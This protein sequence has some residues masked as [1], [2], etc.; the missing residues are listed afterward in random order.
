MKKYFILAALVAV[1][2]TACFAQKSY[3]RK[4]KDLALS[5][6][7][8]DFVA[9]R[10]TIKS[11]LEDPTT[12][13]LAETWYVAGLIGY[14]ENK[15][16]VMLLQLG[17]GGKD[18]IKRGKM[19]IESY[20]YW[21]VADSLAQIPTYDKKGKAKYDTKTP[22]LVAS[23]M[24][25]YYRNFELINYAIETFNAHSYTEAYGA[26]RRY[27]AIPELR[28]MQDKKMQE[29]LVKN[30]D[31]YTYKYYMGMAAYNAEKYDA[32]LAIFESMLDNAE[33]G[34]NAG[35]YIYQTYINIGDSV[36]ANEALDRCI[37]RFPNEPWF[38]Q[39]RINN[40]VNS[41]QMNSAI[42]YLEHAIQADP[43]VQ[44][45]ISKGSILNMLKRY[46]EAIATYES[47]LQIDPNNAAVYEN[48]GFVYNDMANNLMDE[49]AYLSGKEYDA[50]R[51]DSDQLFRTALP[52][53]EKAYEL[54]PDNM[55]YRRNLRS[56]YYRLQMMDKYN[57]IGQ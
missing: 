11:A 33:H 20:D 34:V 22:K 24:L 14:Q 43:Q 56:L 18:N 1:S 2:A 52:Y 31:Y 6:E 42:T 17:K 45:F 32:G 4:A 12:K 19:V 35:Q 50:A 41:G 28:M 37:R 49:A 25:D 46:E 15:N 8:P 47:A 48:Y 39:N 51:A 21:L 44:Y 54:A 7:K 23:G 9:A 26:F 36:K 57:A 29:Q 38:I 27:F 3:V 13:D 5:P 40:L 10:A 16:E 30:E 53:F 55:D